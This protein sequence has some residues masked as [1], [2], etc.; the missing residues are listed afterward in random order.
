MTPPGR[1][2]GNIE[3]ARKERRFKQRRWN[4]CC[5]KIISRQKVIG[6]VEFSNTDILICLFLSGL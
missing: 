4:L 3:E 5:W 1:K 6:T 2:R